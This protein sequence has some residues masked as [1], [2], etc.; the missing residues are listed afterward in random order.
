MAQIN[1][2]KELNGIE[3]IFQG[4]PDAATLDALKANGYRWHRVKKLWYAKQTPERLALAESLADGQQIPAPVK[5][6]TPAPV[7]NLE[8]LGS[9]KPNCYGGAELSKA[10]REEL[11]R[12]GVKNCSVKV[13]NYDHIYI[14]WKATAEDF[15][16]IEEA[17]ERVN[18]WQMFRYSNLYHN[19]EYISESNYN[20][21]T[22]EEKTA[23]FFENIRHNIERFNNVYAGTMSEPRN[24][25]DFYYEL[26]NQGF[27]TLS[28]IIKIANQWNYDNS[29][30][31]TDYFEVGYILDIDIKKPDNF[32]IRENMTEAERA[33]YNQEQEE[34]EAKEAAELEARKAEQ[35]AREEA[36][37]K[38]DAWRTDAETAIYN[39]ITVEDIPEEK[40]PY[41]TGLAGGIG[42]ESTLDELRETIAERIA[43]P[44][45]AAISRKVI[46]KNES[47]FADFC[48]LF[49]DDFKFLEGKGGTASDDIRLK[50]Y[51][52]YNRLTPEQ[53]ET[54]KFYNSDCIAV[55]VGYARYVYIPTESTEIR[56]ATEESAKQTAESEEKSAFYI[57]APIEEQA[58]AIK[59][60]EAITIYQCDGW[61][62][63]NIYAG[64]GT[65]E[66]VTPGNYAQ[67]SGIYVTLSDRKKSRRVFLRNGKECLIYRGIMPE[68]PEEVTSRRISANMR[69]MFNYNEL[70]PNTYNYYKS[71]G[72][73]P[74]FD[75]LPR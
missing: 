69:E 25:R 49:L 68:L 74:I 18:I 34:R 5:E 43:E 21:M 22:E 52:M 3:I 40:Q 14:T 64:S 45:E 62:L 67:Y 30:S 2:N 15:A 33:A 72:I 57:P 9:N 48:K 42:K 20:E 39:D 8:N 61:I 37:A 55:Y 28:A 63:N 12:R 70:M 60:G 17:A 51:E 56:N 7:Y 35:K 66:A 46:F 11:K 29:D 38:Y 26:S 71:Q 32:E 24:E 59:P 19:G 13:S 27:N 58:E 16:S 6:S 31:M 65:V 47:V 50:D 36:R 41:I 73:E 75:T 1:F 10:I 44:E 54:I 23:V 53:R 4:K